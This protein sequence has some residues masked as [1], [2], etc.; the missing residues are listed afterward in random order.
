[1][2]KNNVNPKILP[3]KRLKDTLTT[4]ECS[5]TK[6]PFLWNAPDD[7][8]SIKFFFQISPAFWIS[9]K[10]KKIF[11]NSYFVK[12]FKARNERANVKGA[13][14][15]LQGGPGICFIL[16]V[17]NSKTQKISMKRCSWLRLWS[18]DPNISS[19]IRST[20]SNFFQ[21]FKKIQK[22]STKFFSVGYFS[23]WSSWDWPFIIFEMHVSQFIIFFKKTRNRKFFFLLFFCKD[24]AVF[25]K[26]LLFADCISELFTKF[27]GKSG[28]Y[29]FSSR[30][31]AEDISKFSK[32]YRTTEKKDFKIVVYGVRFCQNFSKFQFSK[33]S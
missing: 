13:V 20:S 2:F 9:K 16:F 14:I 22:N 17:N 19:I 3:K 31:A 4:A 30:Q 27:G 1:M 18:L 12:R 29:G 15:F 28:L 5:I 24:F 11:K 26:T 8:R 10:L 7:P 23:S 6:F 21:K 32:I 33:I 25:W